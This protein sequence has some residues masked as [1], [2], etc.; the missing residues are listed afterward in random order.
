MDQAILVLR[1]L[2]HLVSVMETIAAARSKCEAKE[3]AQSA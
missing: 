2:H 3:D 1:G